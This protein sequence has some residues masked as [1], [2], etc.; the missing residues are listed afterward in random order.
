MT[1]KF[2]LISHCTKHNA[3]CSLQLEM[4]VTKERAKSYSK[5]LIWLFFRLLFTNL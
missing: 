3:V 4:I 2:L 5:D 1:N